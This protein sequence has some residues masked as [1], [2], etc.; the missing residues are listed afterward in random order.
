MK[1]LN[2]ILWKKIMCFIQVNIVS[3]WGNSFL[4]KKYAMWILWEVNHP[5]I[6]YWRT[7]ATQTPIGSIQLPSAASWD[8]GSQCSFSWQTTPCQI[9]NLVLYHI[10]W[11]TDINYLTN[12]ADIDGRR[13]SWDA[14]IIGTTLTRNGECLTV[15]T[16]FNSGGRWASVLDARQLRR[17][18][19]DTLFARVFW[20]KSISQIQSL[21][22]ERTNWIEYFG[23]N[24]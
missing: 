14:A 8:F 12:R 5:V 6:V 24:F 1:E 9:R 10:R 23:Y 16:W 20:C 17:S 7:L 18:G 3:I 11:K 13:K 4:I 2:C 21:V 15:N 22:T 19:T